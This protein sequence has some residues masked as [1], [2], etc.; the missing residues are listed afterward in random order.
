M[1]CYYARFIEEIRE[2]T[3]KIKNRIEIQNRLLENKKTN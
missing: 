3:K 1:K 2:I